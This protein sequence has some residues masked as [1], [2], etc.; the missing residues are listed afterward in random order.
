MTG[1]AVEWEKVTYTIPNGFWL[2]PKPIISDFNLAIENGK[3]LGIIGANGAGK[4]TSLKLAVGLIHPCQGRVSIH[5]RSVAHPHSKK[6]VGFLSEH[7]YIYPNLML[8]EWLSML[9]GL[10]GLSRQALSH[11]TDEIFELL[12]L[13]D[14]KSTKMKFLSK[15]QVQRAGFAQ[16]ILHEPD[17][18]FLDEPMSGLDP[19]WHDRI[20]SYLLDFKKN[21]GTLIFSSHRLDDILRLSDQVAT[22]HDG[23]LV[24]VDDANELFSTENHFR[25]VF[26]SD[27]MAFVKEGLQGT[28]LMKHSNGY[29]DLVLKGEQCGAF[30][31]FISNGQGRLI[32]FGPLPM[33][34]GALG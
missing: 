30:H 28:Q 21:G 7:Q 14:L 23:C 18:L 32:F 10:S 3:S 34:T 11:R 4:T 16:A 33:D 6:S 26:Y 9:G 13:G 15:G 17:I 22:I 5:G 8:G 29:Y 27:D 24:S 19:N 2:K 31:D 12:A 1:F 20:L 25:A